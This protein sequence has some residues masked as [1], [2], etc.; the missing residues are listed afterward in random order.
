M[1]EAVVRTATTDDAQVVGRLLYDFNVEFETA[2]PSAEDFAARF[3]VLL[4][5][6][7]V[8]V[9]LADDAEDA[10][11]AGA[12]DAAA[13]PVGFAFLTLRPTPY[14]DGPVALLEELYVRPGR[15]GQGTGTALLRQA[16]ATCRRR[17]CEE[18]QINVDEEDADT[19]RFYDTH[20]F[21]NQHDG[22]PWRMLFYERTL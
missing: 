11:G 18:M 22:S 1:G 19:R 6:D 4:G 3:A 17:G 5:R 15:R 9:L 2:T 16:M 20:G 21:V 14:A 12:G 7:D 13:G 10:G 8:L